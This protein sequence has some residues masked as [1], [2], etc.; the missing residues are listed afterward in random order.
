MVRVKRSLMTKKRHKKILKATT[1]YRMLN[2]RVFSRAKNAWMKAGLNAYIGRRR[3]KRDFR[4]L[5]TIRINNAVREEGLN[6]SNFINKMYL[7]KVSLNRKVLS[8]LAIS[9]SEV[10]KKIV[11]FVK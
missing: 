6:Y 4:R 3:K 5:W 7:K 1:G 11:A 8:N 2:S 9:N 10:F